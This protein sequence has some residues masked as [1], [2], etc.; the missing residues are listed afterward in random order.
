[1][2]LTLMVYKIESWGPSDSTTSLS[3]YNIYTQVMMVLD[4]EF[5]VD[6]PLY[7]NKNIKVNNVKGL[8][9]HTIYREIC[10]SNGFLKGKIV[11]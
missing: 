2:T 3:S 6:R 7:H 8:P 11:K 9:T 5:T 1:M 4:I 10:D